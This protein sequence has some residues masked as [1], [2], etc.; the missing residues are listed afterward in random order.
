MQSNEMREALRA[1]RRV[2][3]A[4]GWRI[5]AVSTRRARLLTASSDDVDDLGEALERIGADL[6]RLAREMEA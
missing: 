1:A 5:R 3:H 4:V 6:R 2:V